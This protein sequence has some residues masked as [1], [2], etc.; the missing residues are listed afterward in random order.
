M[1]RGRISASRTAARVTWWNTAR[2]TGRPPIASRASSHSSTCQAIASPSRSGSVASTS[3]SALPSARAI[4]PSFLSAP[5]RPGR[6]S[7]S[8]RRDPPS[9]PLPA[10]RAD[11]PALRSPGSR[12]R[13]T[14][15]RS[16][17]WPAI[18]PP[19]PA[20]GRPGAPRSG[21]AGSHRPPPPCP[22]PAAFPSPRLPR[23][24]PVPRP[25]AGGQGR[26][27]RTAWW[28]KGNS[29]ANAQKA[30]VS[31]APAMNQPRQSRKG[32]SP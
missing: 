13:A 28:A 21:T 2:S 23:R 9:P 32:R 22:A 27:R 6:P 31:G 5:C 11:G 26:G 18:R 4:A 12:A 15:Q 10:G 24:D 8:R 17:P 20:S 14:R 3:A 16:S 30:E 1:A 25:L 29:R 19:P 7:R